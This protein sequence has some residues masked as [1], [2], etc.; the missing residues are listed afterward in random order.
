MFKKN[1]MRDA[2]RFESKGEDLAVS[3]VS[4]LRRSTEAEMESPIMLSCPQLVA[5]IIRRKCGMEK[6][7]AESVGTL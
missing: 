4:D 3:V 7:Q 6:F 5:G 1:G 2:E